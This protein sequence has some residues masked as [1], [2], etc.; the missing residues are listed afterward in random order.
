MAPVNAADWVG[1]TLDARY[2]VERILGR[3][4]MGLVLAVR[5]QELDERFALKLLVGDRAGRETAEQRFMREAK[6]AQQIRSPHVMEVNR[7]GRLVSGE[8]YILMEYLDGYDLAQMLERRGAL[9]FDEALRYIIEACAGL[10]AAHRFGIV[11]RDIKPSNLFLVQ[12]PNQP[13]IIKLIDF[14]IS[15]YTPDELNLTQTNAFVGSPL[16]MSPEQLTAAKHVDARSDLFSLGVVLYQLLTGKIPF[17]ADN[18]NEVGQRILHAAPEPP[19]RLRPELPWHV[20]AVIEKCLAKQVAHRYQNA[21][22]LSHALET[23]RPPAEAVLARYL[24]SADGGNTE[25]PRIETVSV[26]SRCS[27][28]DPSRAI[29][30][31]GYSGKPPGT[32]VARP[33]IHGMLP[34][35]DEVLQKLRDRLGE[36]PQPPPPPPPPPTDIIP[37]AVPIPI[38]PRFVGRE[39]D[40]EKMHAVLSKKERWLIQELRRN[41]RSNGEVGEIWLQIEGEAGIGKT[42]LVAAYAH[43]YREAYPGGIFWIDSYDD[44]PNQIINQLGGWQPSLNPSEKELNPLEWALTKRARTL[45]VI[46][47]DLDLLVHATRKAHCFIGPKWSFA[48]N[49]SSF[50]AIHHIIQTFRGPHRRG[51]A[52][53]VLRPL[54]DL[55]A[56]A[57]ALLSIGPEKARQ[58]ERTLWKHATSIARAIKGTP[59]ALQLAV[60]ALSTGNLPLATAVGLLLRRTAQMEA[61]KLSLNRVVTAALQLIIERLTTSAKTLLRTLAAFHHGP[62]STT[63]LTALST[64]T[65]DDVV[66]AMEELDTYKLLQTGARPK[67][68][69]I[70]S[71][72]ATIVAPMLSVD[73]ATIR[74]CLERL[75]RRFSDMRLL[76]R[77]VEASS[78]DSLIVELGYIVQAMPTSK[79]EFIAELWRTLNAEAPRLIELQPIHS[80]IHHQQPTID[81]AGKPI[82]FSKF[83]TQ[84]REAAMEHNCRAVMKCVES[85][86]QETG[87]SW[88]ARRSYHQQARPRLLFTHNDVVNAITVSTDGKRALSGAADGSLNYYDVETAQIVAVFRGSSNPIRRLAIS[89]DGKIAISVAEN[90]PPEVWD[91]EKSCRMGI[92]DGHSGSIYA[93]DIAANGT[94]A[95]TVARDGLVCIWDV[96]TQRALR[97]LCAYPESKVWPISVAAIALSVD[98]R[99]IIASPRGTIWHFDA[100]TGDVVHTAELP[101]APLDLIQTHSRTLV[102]ARGP[103]DTMRIW[104]AC[105][106][107]LICRLE[108]PF[109]PNRVNV[110]ANDTNCFVASHDAIVRAYNLESAELQR[111]LVCPWPGGR[112]FPHHISGITGHTGRVTTVASSSNG[113]TTITAGTDNMVMAWNVAHGPAPRHEDIAAIAA[114]ADGKFVVSADN[115]PGTIVV[116]DVTTQEPQRTMRLQDH[117]QRFFLA[118]NRIFILTNHGMQVRG[119][120]D[121]QLIESIDTRKSYDGGSVECISSDGRRALVKRMNGDRPTWLFW[122]VAESKV[123][124]LVKGKTW[125]SA[126][127]VEGDQVLL[128]SHEGTLGLANF[129]NGTMMKVAE[130]VFDRGGALLA[131]CTEQ[132]IWLSTREGPCLV[133]FRRQAVTHRLPINDAGNSYVQSFAATYDGRLVVTI[134]GG[135]I[136]VWNV[137]T[138][139][140]LT[141]LTPSLELGLGHLLA[142]TPDGR[143]VIFAGRHRGRVEKFPIPPRQAV[144][145]I[146]YVQIMQTHVHF[147]NVCSSFNGNQDLT[148]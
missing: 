26:A 42:E 60:A 100:D 93:V 33:R 91:L 74:D 31:R 16:Y 49:S 118:G 64:M 9:P 127:F 76:Y 103:L 79:E 53:C 123:T 144:G 80:G 139:T 148:T 115:S 128:V 82:V 46:D 112:A 2:K 125:H 90:E 41:E 68:I 136:Q 116:W 101:D 122:S 134:R 141:E 35:P 36:A 3:G 73:P 71:G 88:L 12:R 11:H 113:K 120:I 38:N 19:T 111:E 50:T 20:D 44:L 77:A 62:L 56:I 61:S 109:S 132:R 105:S 137:E 66:A 55:D 27:I 65:D 13:P 124:P 147:A 30:A 15:K 98:G 43:R 138:Q 97:T 75:K 10:A 22:E 96:K 32:S 145:T 69:C 87:E 110:A 34:L 94:R 7:V 48:I 102:F 133:D 47:T 129:E 21:V 28:L 126:T 81:T 72:I 104:D 70:A 67:R 130:N 89:S 39:A 119:L 86:L 135:L 14:G 40:I 95:L 83:L 84:M 99:A 29:A 108:I 85:A 92:L 143:T 121:G 37:F 107:A 58:C 57:M 45:I 51:H 63:T 17:A 8:R 23:L 117:I 52:D 4:G 1:R 5:D 140:I 146:Q 131:T 18:V 114:T 106:G 78:G 54:N 24:D 25:A 6:A 142:I 59:V